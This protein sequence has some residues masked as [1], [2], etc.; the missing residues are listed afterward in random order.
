MRGGDQVLANIRRFVGVARSMADKTVDEFVDYI[1][2]LRDDL[3]ARASQA[4]LDG[5]NA[6][7]LLTIHS[8]KGLEF[9]IVVLAEAG[10]NRSGGN[11]SSILWRAQEGISLTLEPDLDGTYEGR[12][13]PA[14]YNY[15]QELEAREDAAENKRLLYVAATRA[16]DLLIVSGVEPAGESVS[17]LD[18]FREGDHPNSIIVRPTLAVD[19]DA[20]KRS[21]PQA[22]FTVPPAESEEDADAP[23]IGRRGAIPIRS[24]TP[25]TALEHT[26][27]ARYFG[28]LIHLP[29]SAEP[30]LT[31]QSRIGSRT[32]HVPI[33]ES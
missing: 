10:R 17:W 28:P 23:L 9:P 27:G 33:C 18:P 30:W 29:S 25:A 26:N 21:A 1:R 6:V 5:V 8:A 13:R 12:R 20:I 4:A 2:M 22:P 31:Q 24:S 7:R 3:G 19:L 16:A 15:L 14:F 11:A 32:I